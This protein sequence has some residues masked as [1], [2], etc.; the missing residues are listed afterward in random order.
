MAHTSWYY[1]FDFSGEEEAKQAR[2]RQPYFMLEC[3]KIKGATFLREVTKKDILGLTTYG[4][5]YKSA[6][7]CPIAGTY[8]FV[9]DQHCAY[10]IGVFSFTTSNDGGFVRTFFQEFEEI[11]AK[12]SIFSKIQK[13]YKKIDKCVGFQQI[14]QTL[15]EE[16]SNEYNISFELLSSFNQKSYELKNQ[17]DNL[18]KEIE[19][20]VH[21]YVMMELRIIHNQSERTVGINIQG[22]IKHYLEY[23]LSK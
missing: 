21:E 20:M 9:L 11:S 8:Y 23:F 18:K 22:T 12:A 13:E 19:K 1:S 7:E 10:L 17:I 16:D 6:V 5:L 3:S 2:E 4:F 14:V 15:V